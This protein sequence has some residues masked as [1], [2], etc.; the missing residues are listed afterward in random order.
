[1]IDPKKVT[2]YNRN[3][4]Q[5][6]EWL[7]YCVCVAGK[8]SEIE[9]PKVRKFCLDPRFGF[10]LKPFDLIRKLLGVSSVE[11][12]GLMQHL[13]KYKI[14]PYKQRYNSFADVVELLPDNLSKVTI[15]ELQ[16]VRGISTKTSRFFLTHSRED[17]DE[18][19]LDTHI[20]RFLQEEGYRVPT[21]TPQNPTEYARVANIFRRIANYEGKSVTDLDLEVWT[22]YS[23]GKA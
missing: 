10:N 13:K 3:E 9:S 16:E 21:S 19:V 12:D 7:L 18:P 15:D 1:M 2:D 11:E 23:Y 17:F 8:K 22:Q 4:W 6:Q 20:L 14:A 5:L